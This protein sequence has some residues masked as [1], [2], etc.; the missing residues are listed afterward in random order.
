[1]KKTTMLLVILATFVTFAAASSK[2]S[3]E[4]YRLLRQLFQYKNHEID[5]LSAM[6]SYLLECQNVS[7]TDL[8]AKNCTARLNEMQSE[9][10]QME[11]KKGVLAQ[12][13]ASHIQQ[14][15][16]EEW[17]FIGLLADDKEF[18]NLAH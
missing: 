1:M 18:S 15:K 17:L 7:D 2:I 9:V 8:K 16:D 13:I 14:H 4:S 12:T 6:S 3:D 10:N 11:I 5:D